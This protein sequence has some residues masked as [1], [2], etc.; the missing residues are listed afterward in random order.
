MSGYNKC[1]SWKVRTKLWQILREGNFLSSSKNPLIFPVSWLI[2]PRNAT[3]SAGRTNTAGRTSTQMFRLTNA[4]RTTRTA[5]GS[6]QTKRTTG[7]AGN[8]TKTVRTA[9]VCDKC[10]PCKEAVVTWRREKAL[11]EQTRRIH[12]AT[13]LTDGSHWLNPCLLKLMRNL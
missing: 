2:F 13:T 3:T 5:G 9:E 4:T 11:V 7:T 6:A 10:N 12:W 1:S 8:V